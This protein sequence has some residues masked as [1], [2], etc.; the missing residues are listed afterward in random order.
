MFEEPDEVLARVQDDVRRAQKRAEALPRLQ[1]AVDEIRATAR[2]QRRDISV[3]VDSSGRVTRFEIL[4][5][6]FDRGGRR[7]SS[8]VMALIASAQKG[9]RAKT[10]AATAELL[11]DDDPIASMMRAE[12]GVP[13]SGPSGWRLGGR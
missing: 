9:A 8:D 11:G 12:V 4:D 13:D 7:V 1:A 10:L 2:S 5:G 6:A 3:E